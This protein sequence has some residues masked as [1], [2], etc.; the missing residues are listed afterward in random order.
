MGTHCYTYSFRAARP[1]DI[2]AITS[3]YNAA[4][5]AGG[6]SADTSPRTIEQ[7][8]EWVRSHEYP[9]GVFVVEAMGEDGSPCVVGFG[10]MSQFHAR[11][12]YDG[13]TDYAYYVHPDW[14]H[15]HVGSFLMERLIEESKH[16]GMRKAVLLIF[17]DNEA[18]CALARKYGFMRYGVMSH[19]AYDATGV[20][21]DMSYWDLDL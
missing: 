5:T 21:R 20:L 14:R 18:S 15:K 9:Y 6:A 17:A 13:V 2:P 3:I 8:T 12:G 4:V 19:A 7:R 11:A 16:R 10:A 1:E